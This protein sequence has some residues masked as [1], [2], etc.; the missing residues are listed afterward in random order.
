MDQANVLLLNVAFMFD[1]KSKKLMIT[2]ERTL[3]KL[4]TQDLLMY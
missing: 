2:P 3:R 4:L 1:K